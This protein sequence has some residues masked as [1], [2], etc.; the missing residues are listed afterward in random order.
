MP[1]ICIVDDNPVVALQLKRAVQAAGYGDVLSF[2]QPAQALAHCLEHR[3]DVVLVDFSMPEMDGVC[4][5]R[6]LQSDARTRD[7]VPA[8]VSGRAVG[9]FKTAAYSA[10]AVDVLTKPVLPAELRFKLG[11]LQQEALRR[12][13]AAAGTLRTLVDPRPFVRCLEQMAQIH[14]TSLGKRTERMAAYAVALGRA[15]GMPEQRLAVLG[16]AARLHDLGM[17]AAPPAAWTGERTLRPSERERLRDHTLAGYELLRELPGEVF[18]LAAEIAIGHHEHWDG[19][20]YPRGLAGAEIPLAARI[21]ALADAYESV[22]S[23]PG[24][25]P[26]WLIAR[27]QALIEADDGEHFDPRLVDAFRRVRGELVQIKR[28]FDG[29]VADLARLPRPH[30]PRQLAG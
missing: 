8:M 1:S 25:D 28:H 23:I 17:V 21:V 5:I 22:T 26:A 12:R 6:E 11:R 3:T 30:L 2:T 4:F 20:G 18:A 15:L 19:T 16:E 9:E 29:D 13:E 10:G 7:I 14:D 24:H 27:A